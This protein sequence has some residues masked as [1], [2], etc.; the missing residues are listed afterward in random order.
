MPTREEIHEAQRVYWDGAGGDKWLRR[1]D[2]IDAN[3]APAQRAALA[4][5]DIRAGGR[6]L[7]IGCGT[8]G[9]TLALAERVGVNGRVLAL[10]ISH[11]MI[12]VARN[13]ALSLPQVECVVGDAATH[14][15]ERES[16]DLAFSRF[17]IMFFGD[18]PA[19][20]ANIR[21]ALKPN[22]KLVFVC[23]RPIDENPWMRV[24]LRAVCK[25][26]PRPQRPGPEDPGPFA[27]GDPARAT[28]VLTAA[29]F[30]TP[31]IE[32]FD[33]DID[34]ALA[35]GLEAAVETASNV[36]AASAALTG[37]PDDVRAAAVDELRRELAPLERDGRVALAAAVWIVSAARGPA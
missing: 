23:W 33:F 26:A 37:Q 12:G 5:A 22:G 28:R 3:V 17:G 21:G 6:V 11:A 10:D 25:H 1:S 16:F 15:F 35:R 32:P 14:A 7:D 34:L 18:P 9:S 30:A 27:F 24:P 29:G 19:A 20:F 36:G 31:R 2:D 8:G 13:R 4:T